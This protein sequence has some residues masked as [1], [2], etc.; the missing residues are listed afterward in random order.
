MYYKLVAHPFERGGSCTE[1]GIAAF[2]PG[3]WGLGCIGASDCCGSMQRAAADVAAVNVEA[4]NVAAEIVGAGWVW[5]CGGGGSALGVCNAVLW[6]VKV[7]LCLLV[8]SVAWQYSRTALAR[9]LAGSL[10]LQGGP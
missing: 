5:L 2:V 8:A 6:W 4:A 9:C 7:G 10:H 3:G 1:A